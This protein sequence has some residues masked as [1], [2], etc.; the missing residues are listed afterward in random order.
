MGAP[1]VNSILLPFDEVVISCFLI[2]AK[3][4]EVRVQSQQRGL[5]L[6][7]FL[8]LFGFL[9]TSAHAQDW[10]RTA[11]GMDANKPRVAIAD[12]V[13]RADSAKA[14]STLFTQ[15]VRDDLQFSGILELPSPSFYP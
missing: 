14:H 13:P 3:H 12:F 2:F 4:S 10:F 15:I 7:F 9:G 6:F 1:N 5:R 11:I 8:S